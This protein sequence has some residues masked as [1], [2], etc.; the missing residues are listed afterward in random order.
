MISSRSISALSTLS[1]A[2][3]HALEKLLALQILAQQFF[4]FGHLLVDLDVGDDLVV[5]HGGDAVGEELRA[6][7][8]GEAEGARPSTQ[9]GGPQSE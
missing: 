8:R 4:R 1:L 7:R 6:R 3:L 2:S 9:E 5:D